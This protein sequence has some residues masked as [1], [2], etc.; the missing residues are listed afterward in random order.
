MISIRPLNGTGG[1]GRNRRAGH[2]ALDVESSPVCFIRPPVLAV[3]VLTLLAALLVG[4]H[5]ASA[6][7]G[8]APCA[9]GGAVADAANNPGLVGDC[10]TLLAARDTLAGNATLDWSMSTPIDQ[11]EGVTVAGTP[12]RVTGLWFGHTESA[13]IIPAGLGNLSKLQTLGL[14]SNQLTG[15][16]PTE[17][18]NLKE[19]V[20]LD[21]AWN[22]LTGPIPSE[23]GDLVN[24]RRLDLAQNQ[25]SGPIPHKLGG[26]SNLVAL[27]LGGNRLT[28]PIPTWLG[29]LTNLQDLSLA[30]NQLTGEI[31]AELGNLNNLRELT[32]SG[33]RLT[34]SIPP[35]L[36]N[37]SRLEGLYIG[38][39]DLTGVVPTWLGDFPNL[40]YL[41]L[42][43]NRLTGRIPTS[44]GNLSDLQILDLSKNQLTGEIPASFA[45]F[46][47]L[48]L[49]KLASNNLTG[50]VPPNFRNVVINDLGD[51]NLPH[52]DVL[53]S[54]MTVTPGSLIPG[55]D[56]Y[57][58]AYSGSVG[59]IPLTV[60]LTPTNDHNATFQFFDND[61]VELVDADD[62][63]AGFQVELGD[64]VPAVKIRVVS[65][66]GQASHTYLVTD[67]GNRYD[68][69]DDGAI[70]R[71]EVIEAIKDYFADRITREE[72][73]EVIK[74]YFSG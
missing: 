2:K 34:V 59:L 7:N 19:L 62:S 21:L 15:D 72:A 31:P 43:R 64:G 47:N 38:L 69:N 5:P 12:L 41:A 30:S 1:C 74:L 58:T 28:G 48:F 17:L 54:G 57:R 39:N 66:D 4:A 63:L 27:R 40:A 9:A 32:L 49:I 35:E 26:L 50:C 36:A 42:S 71:E 22:G 33:N 3:V 14:T 53:L 65:R 20:S 68:V 51:L 73:I 61:D 25:L 70:Q 16:I 44:L 24:L 11:W 67:L 10:E 46:T 45:D 60:T 29:T 37:L 8:V 52:C 18:G 13:G 6:Q 23:L 55:F 56:P